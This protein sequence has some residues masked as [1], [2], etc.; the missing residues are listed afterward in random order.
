MNTLAVAS[1]LSPGLNRIPAPGGIAFA[2]SDRHAY[3]ADGRAVVAAK[4]EEDGW[5]LTR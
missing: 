5:K 4:I 2:S 1:G 3:D